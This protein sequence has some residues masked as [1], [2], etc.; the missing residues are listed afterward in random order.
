MCSVNLYYWTSSAKNQQHT[1]V[2]AVTQK[3]PKL[4]EFSP[5]LHSNL[6]WCCP[7]NS[8]CHCWCFLSSPQGVEP[9]GNFHQTFSCS[10]AQTGMVQ[11]GLSGSNY[12]GH[13]PGGR[14]LFGFTLSRL[15]Q[16]D[17]LYGNLARP[18]VH[19][20]EARLSSENRAAPLDF[21]E[22]VFIFRH[23]GFHQK[24]LFWF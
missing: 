6:K 16:Q 19:R 20:V 3:Q 9:L 1:P 2:T 15:C 24:L 23:E 5:K 22:A 11:T 13:S 7:G 8:W 10:S 18:S 12:C 14:Q 4:V 17:R 21:A